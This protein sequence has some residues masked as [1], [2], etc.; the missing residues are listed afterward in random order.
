MLNNEAE[1]ERVTLGKVTRRL[2]PFMFLL[3]IF[4]VLDRFNVT[5]AVLTMK[6]DVGLNDEMYGFGTGIFFIGYFFFEIPSN[7]LM[8]RFGARKWIARIMFTWGVIASSMMFMKTPMH[9][10]VLRFL[11]GVAEAGFFPGMMLYLTYWFPNAARGQAAARFI[12]AGS[13]AGIIGG[14]LGALLLELNGAGGL[15]GWQWLFLIEGI[16]SF[17]LGFAVLYYMTDKPENAHWLL[18]EE[19]EWLLRT[20]AREQTHRQKFH[21]MSLGQ[22]LRYPRVL[23]LSALFFLNIFSGSGLGVFSNLIVQQRT[24]WSDQ[25]I[26]LVGTLPAIIG[27]IAMMLAAAHSDRTHERR[28]HTAW[29]LLVAALGIVLAA[30]TRSPTMIITALCVVS[31]GMAIFNGPFWALT[32]G[33]LSGAAAAGGIAFINSVGNSGSFFGPTLMGYLKTHTSAY[34]IGLYLLAGTFVLGAITAFL[35]PPDPAQKDEGNPVPETEPV[36]LESV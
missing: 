25:K 19:R 12:V 4:A 18:P 14:P 3:Y 9:F 34:E 17:L 7:V 30:V 33:F 28:L 23:H 10:Y 5:V 13:V 24:H 16:P 1:L 22:A 31:I 11:L 21:H 35:L 6:K 20:L 2:I 26:L 29:G 36:P 32:T 8:A 27:A 15:R